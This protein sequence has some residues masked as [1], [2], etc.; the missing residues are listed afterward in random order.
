[1]I[2]FWLCYRSLWLSLVL[3]NRCFSSLGGTAFSL[4]GLLVLWSTGS[5]ACR[6]QY[7]QHAGSVV[8]VHGLSCPTACRI[9]LDQGLNLCF[10]HWQVES[11]LS[12]YQESPTLSFNNRMHCNVTSH[13]VW[14]VVLYYTHLL[15]TSSVVPQV[16]DLIFKVHF[17]ALDPLVVWWYLDLFS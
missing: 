12:C 3:T 5:G 4:Q 13:W 15:H 11:Y 10:L 2:Y 16:G 14:G 17:C 1:M 8:A 9:S 6:L 7:L